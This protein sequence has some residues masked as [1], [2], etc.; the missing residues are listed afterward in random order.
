MTTLAEGTLIAI[1]D[2][3]PVT[4]EDP[5]DERIFWFWDQMHHPHAVTP[6]TSSLDGPAFTEGF[7]RACRALSMPFKT[8]EVRTWNY[9]LYFGD[10]PLKEDASEAAAREMRMA[11][12]MMRRAPRI[13]EDWENVYLPQ[14]MKLNAHLRDYDYASA[15]A[16]GLADL[17]GESVEIRAQAWDLH[18]QTVMPAMGAATEFASLYEKTFGTPSGNEHYRMLQGFPNKS[19][20]AG[21]ALFDIA[22]EVRSDSGLARLVAETP[23]ADFL[24]RLE[25]TAPG[26]EM[27]ARLRVY[28]DEYGWR[29]DQFELMDASWREDPSPVVGNLK[30]YLR[31]GAVDPKTEQSKAAAER[32]RLVAGMLERAP[33]GAARQRLVT[34]HKMAQA[35][36]PIQE[37]H[38]FY[39]DQMNTVLLRR[40]ILEIGR[41]LAAAGAVSDRDDAFF[42][43]VGEAQEAVL[44]PQPKWSDTVASRRAEM[45]R[46]S[47]VVPPQFLGTRPPPGPRQ[48]VVDRFWGLDREPSRDPKVITGHGASAGVL[49]GTAKVVRS[50]GEADKLDQGDILVCEMTMP[51]WT[52][53]FSIVGAVVA[54]SGGVLS[55]CAIVAREYGIPCVTGTRV[56]TQRIKDGQTLIVDGARGI[57]RIEG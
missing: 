51:P 40:P 7:G 33:D 29:S 54:D 6:M 42:L 10:V 45:S 41:R 13:M 48:D 56:G 28:L 9:Y 57:V 30:A 50:L 34:F 16:S 44:D 3:F 39:I 18:F 53:L 19:V 14:V 38:N 12:Q 36:L 55:H 5:E 23:A 35:Y 47:R 46:W 27:A 4:W 22:Q 11:A 20:E 31:D 49:T 52:P 21:Q 8:S 25:V 43:T 26:K 1:P 32:E 24:T 37:N 15:S 2:D 17:L